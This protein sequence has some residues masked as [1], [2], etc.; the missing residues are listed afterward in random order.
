MASSPTRAQGPPR[1]QRLNYCHVPDSRCP[2]TRNR[3]PSEV[4]PRHLLWTS[5]SRLTTPVPC[6]TCASTKPNA[7]I[8]CP[9]QSRLRSTVSVLPS[10]VQAWSLQFCRLSTRA[11]RRLS[12]RVGAGMALVRQARPICADSCIGHECHAWFYCAT[13]SLLE[14]H[15]DLES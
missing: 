11:I 6:L 13:P 15:Q 9:S 5:A 10:V 2:D 14:K 1:H 4:F 3:R 7:P 12:S 8:P